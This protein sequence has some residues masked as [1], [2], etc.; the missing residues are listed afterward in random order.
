MS[1]V[2][3]TMLHF[4]SQLCPACSTMPNQYSP[5]PAEK[6]PLPSTFIT[7]T[8]SQR[9]R[10]PSPRSGRSPCDVECLS[11]HAVLRLTTLPCL[12][13]NANTAMRGPALPSSG[14]RQHPRGHRK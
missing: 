5:F 6:K 8:T 4:A 11:N 1:I 9:T 3:A 10:N 13:H 7:N 14:G 2:S 12:I